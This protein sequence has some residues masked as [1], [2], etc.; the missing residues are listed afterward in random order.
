MLLLARSKGRWG[1]LA[2]ASCSGGGASAPALLRRRLSASFHRGQGEVV[3]RIRERHLGERRPPHAGCVPSDRFAG[4]AH[5]VPRRFGRHPIRSH[6]ARAEQFFF[7]QLSKSRWRFTIHDSG[8]CRELP[9]HL[10]SMASICALN[11]SSSSMIRRKSRLRVQR[12]ICNTTNDV[13]APTSNPKKN[14]DQRSIELRPMREPHASAPG[15]SSRTTG[16]AQWPASIM[17]ANGNVGDNS[18]PFTG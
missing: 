18:P 5:V 14:M 13:A 3:H 2:G 9:F 1:A 6:P 11:L 4:R 17:R 16:P 12:H 7:G 15:V 10:R 8:S